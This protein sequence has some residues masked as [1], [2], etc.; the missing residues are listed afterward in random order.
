MQRLNKAKPAPTLKQVFA[1]YQI[2]RALKPITLK[3]YNQ[4]INQYLPEWLDIPVTSITKDMIEAKYRSIPH[5]AMANSTMRTLRAVL[6][7][8]IAK[9]D[10]P[11]GTPML[12]NNVVRRLTELKMWHRDKRR[13]TVLS[14]HDL[15]P[16]FQGVFSLDNSTMRDFLLLLI[17]T[18]MRK[19][20]ALNLTWSRVDLKDGTITLHEEDTKTSESITIPLSTYAWN[21]LMIRNHGARSEFVFPNHD[22]TKPISAAEKSKAFVVQRS[23]IKFCLHDLRRTFMSVADDL[24]IKNEVIKALVNHKTKDV[25][26]G[27]ICRSVERLRRSTQRVT[28]AIL[29]YGGMNT[30]A[31]ATQAQKIQQAA[32]AVL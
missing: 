32:L 5:K 16:W 1:D 31:S 21:M 30:N 3:N 7:Y 9:Y 14:K 18:G 23:G 17:F 20:E 6:H 10:K 29:I 24:D 8:A 27:Y 19:H 2:D 12:T 22:G 26:E 4:R 28:D 13:K 11:D 25:T 15:K